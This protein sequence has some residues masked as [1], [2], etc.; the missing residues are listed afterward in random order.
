MRYSLIVSLLFL[1]TGI[2][3]AQEPQVVPMPS[4]PLPERRSRDVPLL[5]KARRDVYVSEY[6]PTKSE[7]KLLAPA[8]EDLQ[9]FGELIHLPDSGLSGLGGDIGNEDR[10]PFTHEPLGGG[11][12][13]AARGS[14]D[15]GDAAVEPVHDPLLCVSSRHVVGT[16][17]CRF[18]LPWT[19]DRA[20]RRGPNGCGP[21]ATAGVAPFDRPNGVRRPRSRGV[22]PSDGGSDPRRGHTLD[23]GQ[24]RGGPT[25][26]TPRGADPMFA[27]VRAPDL[28]AR[29]TESLRRRAAGRAGRARAFSGLRYARWAT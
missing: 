1:A 5:P 27:Q 12:A 19:P 24:G 16:S 7:K 9:T 11:L 21:T 14:G 22:M 20:T 29:V 13:D 10:G 17:I 23:A 25:R 26:S 2:C 28:D 18:V 4:R 8:P 3:F 6:Q 15:E